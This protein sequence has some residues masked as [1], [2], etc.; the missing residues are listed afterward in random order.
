MVDLRTKYV[1][2]KA[3]AVD[4]AG[5]TQALLTLPVNIATSPAASDSESFASVSSVDS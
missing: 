1:Q 3:A 4:G 5:E 2:N